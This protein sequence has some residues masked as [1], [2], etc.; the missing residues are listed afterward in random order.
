MKKI[1][2]L[3]SAF[4]IL[5]IVVFV[6]FTTVVTYDRHKRDTL[7]DEYF[8]LQQKIVLDDIYSEYLEVREGN[9]INKCEILEKQVE[10]SLELS[11]HLLKKLKTINQFGIVPS[12]NRIKYVYI[13][14]NVK[15]WLQQQK[16]ENECGEEKNIVIYFYPEISGSTSEKAMWDTKTVF[17][18]KKLETLTNNCKVDGLIALP[19]IKNIPILDQMIKDFNITQPLAIVINDN[20]LYDE[21]L[22]PIITETFLDQIGC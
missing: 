16:I 12:D 1:D 5:I 19:Y 22:P 13:L 8:I 7:F 15:L 17:F 11:N 4:L 18:E 14:T 9:N 3:L 6:T 21:D 10:S 20:I 2:V